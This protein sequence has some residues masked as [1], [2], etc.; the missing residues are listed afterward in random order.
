MADEPKGDSYETVGEAK[1][2]S[3]DPQDDHSAARQ[4]EDRIREL[5]GRVTTLEKLFAEMESLVADHEARFEE[6]AGPAG[7]RAPKEPN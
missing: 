7:H 2:A 1:A 3:A 4:L 5:D 6:L